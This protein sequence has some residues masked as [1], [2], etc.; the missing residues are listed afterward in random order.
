MKLFVYLVAIT[1]ILQFLTAHLYMNFNG[2][3]KSF[4]NYLG[5][6]TGLG[7]FLTY[8]LF[9]WACF[10]TTWWIPIAAFAVSWAIKIMIPPIYTIELFASVLFPIS[11]VV[12]IILLI[13]GV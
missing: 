8:G 5:W 11:L 3:S 12:S 7:G 9:I 6:I 2:S 13:L 10:M 1:S 4:Y